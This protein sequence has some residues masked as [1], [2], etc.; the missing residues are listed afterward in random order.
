MDIK[1]SLVEVQLSG[2]KMQRGRYDCTT[3]DVMAGSRL[4]G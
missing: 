4:A 3:N 2:I 1:Q